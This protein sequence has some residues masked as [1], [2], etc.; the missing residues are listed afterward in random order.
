[1]WI[2]AN[3][4]PPKNRSLSTSYQQVMHVVVGSTK[5][6][7]REYKDGFFDSGKWRATTFSE[8][9][10]G[11]LRFFL[12]IGLIEKP[13]NLKL[14]SSILSNLTLSPASILSSSSM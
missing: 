4:Y 9:E 7:L 11:Y 12:L 1:M 13:A 5:P 10:V 6:S 3:S 2:T 14:S 8:C